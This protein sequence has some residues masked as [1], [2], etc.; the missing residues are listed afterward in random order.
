MTMPS[1][2]SCAR[3]FVATGGEFEPDFVVHRLAADVGDLFAGQ[4]GDVRELRHGIDQVVHGERAGLVTASDCAAC[5]PAMVPPVA[6][7]TIFS[8]AGVGIGGK[9]QCHR[10]CQTD[11]VF[12]HFHNLFCLLVCVGLI[13]G[14]VVWDLFVGRLLRGLPFRDITFRG[15]TQILADLRISL[16]GEIGKRHTDRPCRS[17]EAAAGHEHNAAVLGQPEEHINALVILLEESGE[18][19]PVGLFVPTPSDQARRNRRPGC[20]PPATSGQVRRTAHATGGDR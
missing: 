16:L 14:C 20:C 15:L 2:S 12:G 5:A 4:Y 7:T 11:Q 18:L 1:T 10:C 13:Y 6:R 8:L 17:A 3:Q 9:H 19:R